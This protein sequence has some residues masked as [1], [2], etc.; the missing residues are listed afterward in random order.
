M[1]PNLTSLRI[2]E[3]IIHFLKKEIYDP[4]MYLDKH[5]NLIEAGMD[6]FSLLNML[7]FIEK[8]FN[9]CIPQE[10]INETRMKSVHNLTDL[11]YALT[12][13]E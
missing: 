9:V 5:T 11:I 10:E 8:K 3:G 1:K 2:E 7:M 13:K 4:S 6:S 12:K